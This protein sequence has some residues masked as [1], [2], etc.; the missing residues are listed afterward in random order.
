[1]Q[2]AS[3]WQPPPDGGDVAGQKEPKAS[4]PAEPLEPHST[5]TLEPADMVEEGA[6]WMADQ[7]RAVPDIARYSQVQLKDL[8]AR[9]PRHLGAI[10][11]VA[12]DELV[13]S[14]GEWTVAQ[15]LEKFKP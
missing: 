5:A 13:R 10:W 6:R 9:G 7:L 8:A 4:E 11:K 14:Y 1:M 3:E 12:G 15:I 2:S